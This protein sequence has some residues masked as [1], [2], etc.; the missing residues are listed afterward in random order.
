[1]PVA[2]SGG[3]KLNTEPV[4]AWMLSAVI[5]FVASSIIHMMLSYH[6]SD[7]RKTPNE[8]DLQDTLR[9]F[10]IPPGVEAGILLPSG[11]DEPRCWW[12]TIKHVDENDYNLSAGR[13]KPQIAEKALDDDPTL[14]IRETLAIERDIVVC[15]EKLL[16]EVEAVE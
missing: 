3:N 1:M 6:R 9:K 15:L 10:S 7:Y 12:T 14:L 16:Q 2:F 4:P 8:E 11:S 13:Y 5:V